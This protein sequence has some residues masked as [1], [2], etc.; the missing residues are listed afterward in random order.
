MQFYKISEVKELNEKLVALVLVSRASPNPFLS[1]E[2]ENLKKYIEEA[3]QEKNFE[4]LFLLES[5]IYERQAYKKAVVDGKS[6]NEFAKDDDKALIE[7]K[8]FYSELL[9]IGNTI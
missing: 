7:F 6:I 1:K 9:K 3:K 4:D 5:V 8:E 2:L